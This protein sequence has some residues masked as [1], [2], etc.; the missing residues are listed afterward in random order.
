VQILLG[1][2]LL[3]PKV[4]GANSYTITKDTIDEK[5]CLDT[6]PI[7]CSEQDSICHVVGDTMST[8]IK[9]VYEYMNRSTTLGNNNNNN[10]DNN[11]HAYAGIPVIVLHM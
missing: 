10:D 6:E 1:R 4:S 3:Q 8:D 9:S 2:L 7:D 5:L 11:K